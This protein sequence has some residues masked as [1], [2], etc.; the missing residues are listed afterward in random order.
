MS[1]CTGK[2]FESI[3][4]VNIYD[5]NQHLRFIDHIYVLKLYIFSILL[6]NQYFHGGEDY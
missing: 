6:T 1:N 2:I 4:V 5:G 3:K